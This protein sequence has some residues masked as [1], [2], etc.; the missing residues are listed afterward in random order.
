[1]FIHQLD[2]ATAFLNG[3]LD[4]K[5]YLSQPEGFS[6]PRKEHLICKLKQS[7]CDFKQSPKH[8]NVAKN[9]FLKSTLFVQSSADQCIYIREEDNIKE[10]IAVNMD[11]LVIA[12][13][14]KVSMVL[15]DSK[16]MILVSFIIVLVLANAMKEIL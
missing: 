6:I 5:I 1:M 7:L 8:W 16:Q 9:E 14:T 3:H 12:T 4:E 13:D 10:L 2:V 11:D 15:R